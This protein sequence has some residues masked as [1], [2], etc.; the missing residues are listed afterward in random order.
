MSSDSHHVSDGLSRAW[1]AR[2]PLPDAPLN[3]LYNELAAI[4]VL[5]PVLML[6]SFVN[7]FPI[8]F[9]DT[10]AYVL[11]GFQ[12]IFIAERSTVYSLFLKYAGGPQSLWY[13]AF[14]QC[15][16]VAFVMVE[17]ARSLKPQ[18][19][20]WTFL[21]IG[22]ILT[23]A[24]GL[25]WYA[26]QIEPDCFVAVTAMAIYLLAFHIR[27]LGFVRSVLLVL[28]AAFAASTHSSHMGLALG[29]LAVLIVARLAAMFVRVQGFPK[30]SVWAPMA[31]C[32]LAF[33]IVFACNYQ[34][35]HNIFFSKAG[36]I[37][38]EA[39]MMQDG[40]IKPVLDT[41]CP[42]AAY[43]IC[44]YKD[45][46]P[47]RADAYLWEEKIS[48]FSRLGG[49]RKLEEESAHLAALSLWR[50]PVSNAAWAGIDTLLEFFAVATG[51]GIEPQEWVLDREFQKT[52]PHQMDGY[53]HAYQQRGDI[54]FLPL[55]FLHV[56]I[57]VLSI[58][59]IYLL[60]RRAWRSGDWNSATLPAFVLI[61]LLGNAFI[62]G[63]FSGPHSRYQS[64]LVWLPTF[65][66]LLAASSGTEIFPRRRTK[67]A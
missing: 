17:F 26:A 32:A 31:S 16:I 25:P 14:V 6:A 37:F 15:V 12:H 21:I 20:L 38:L 36:S 67:T 60:F 40:L 49:F 35:T 1:H 65:V 34:F 11:E 52:I 58:V 28:C 4:V 54:W 3:R 61:A 57:A 7:G 45:N 62:C 5:V 64:R 18:L 9:Y 24:T 10:G 13:V 19:S 50:Y 39:R 55:N 29:L 63:V 33:A 41:D 59:G 48:P 30:P 8:I 42:G 51:D 46:L 43:K 23:L 27:D 22:L 44:P 56:P 66:L 53:T 47:P 2:I